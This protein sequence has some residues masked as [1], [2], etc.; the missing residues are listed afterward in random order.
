MIY[1]IGSFRELDLCSWVSCRFI[2]LQLARA[3]A[4]K[5]KTDKVLLHFV[6]HL[7]GIDGGAV[8]IIEFMSFNDV[9]WSLTLA[10]VVF[11]LVERFLGARR[12]NVGAMCGIE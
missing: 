9:V 2:F 12:G 8:G 3:Q 10:I 1:Y 7:D 6:I 11:V 5:L 4:R